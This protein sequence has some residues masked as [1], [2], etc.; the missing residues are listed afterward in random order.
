MIRNSAFAFLGIIVINVLVIYSFLYMPFM[1][2]TFYPSFLPGPIYD[3]NPIKYAESFPVSTNYSSLTSG[4]PQPLFIYNISGKPILGQIIDI[5]KLN[6]SQVTP[7]AY[8]RVANLA[9]FFSNYT[10]TKN[11][12]VYFLN[13]YYYDNISEQPNVT[14]IYLNISDVYASPF[15]TSYPPSDKVNT[16]FSFITTDSF[17]I[18]SYASWNF[19]NIEWHFGGNIS[20]NESYYY[21]T[22]TLNLNKYIVVNNSHYYYDGS[23]STR[24]TVKPWGVSPNVISSYVVYNQSLSIPLILHLSANSVKHQ[25]GNYS[26]VLTPSYPPKVNPEFYGYIFYNY[27]VYLSLKVNVY[28]GSSPITFILL[29]GSKVYATEERYFNFTLDLKETSI[30]PKTFN[31]SLYTYDSI[32]VGSYYVD[33]YWSPGYILICPQIYIIY[34]GNLK[35]FKLNFFIQN[36]MIETP[37]DWVFNHEAFTEIYGNNYADMYLQQV[38]YYYGLNKLLSEIVKNFTTDE[39]YEKY[40]S[41]ELLLL[42][43]EISMQINYSNPAQNYTMALVSKEGSEYQAFMQMVYIASWSLWYTT[44][45]GS[46]Y[47]LGKWIPWTYGLFTGFSIPSFY[48][49][50]AILPHII[51]NS[52]NASYLFFNIESFRVTSWWYENVSPSNGS[53]H[54][55]HFNVYSYVPKEGDVLVLHKYYNFSN[56]VY[57]PTSSTEFIVMENISSGPDGI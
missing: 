26:Y 57:I 47:F 53:I 30:S 52:S 18:Q 28:N 48:N 27:L 10:I 13:P 42:S 6:A 19:T 33:R 37:P 24:I 14:E 34:N 9:G 32:K 17:S 22:A 55:D 44:F 15:Y 43:S 46:Y 25:I 38:G 12:S 49:K 23:L 3:F 56:I 45:N 1:F 50:T 4:N 51:L 29:N 39:K 5:L 35:L 7:E 41:W 20:Q 16:S 8:W 40:L 21:Y 11:Y 36:H 54:M 31:I 2:S